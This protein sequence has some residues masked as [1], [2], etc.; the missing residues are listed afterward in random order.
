MRKKKKSGIWVNRHLPTK[1][2]KLKNN[3]TS[4]QDEDF[5]LHHHGDVQV[6]SVDK[7]IISKHEHLG[8]GSKVLTGFIDIEKIIKV[9]N[10]CGDSRV[11][12]LEKILPYQI[13][14]LEL[15]FCE[16]E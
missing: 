15:E 2:L 11:I 13:L 1:N 12:F 9:K 5:F 16:E 8:D 10:E 4:L 3:I 14:E 6:I 7:K